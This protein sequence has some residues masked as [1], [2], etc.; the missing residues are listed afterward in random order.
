MLL[1]SRQRHA[2]KFIES[3][4]GDEWSGKRGS[5]KSASNHRYVTPAPPYQ[6]LQV[7]KRAGKSYSL[8]HTQEELRGNDS[9]CAVVGHYNCPEGVRHSPPMLCTR[10]LG[11]FADAMGVLAADAGAK[12]EIRES[13]PHA[14]NFGVNV[15]RAELW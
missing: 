11:R 6:L 2:M 10:R 9:I 7:C 4:S 14:Q 15:G 12:Q 13:L 8:V 5:P 1:L 3:S